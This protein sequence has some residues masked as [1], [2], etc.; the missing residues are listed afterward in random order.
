MPD[1]RDHRHV[2]CVDGNRLVY[3]CGCVNVID[4]ESGILRSVVKCPAHLAERKEVGKLG[5]DYYATM[6]TVENGI[7]QCRRYLEQLRE[8]IGHFPVA[9]G[10]LALEIGCGMSM[11]VPGLLAD[12]YDYRGVEPSE[13]A[14]EWTASTFDVRVHRGTIQDYFDHYDVYPQL[15][16]AA[17]VLEHL[18]DAPGTIRRC[19]EALQPGGEFWIIVPDD[20]D[21]LNP[22]HMW[23]FSQDTLA[24]NLKA[25]GLIVD[26][27]AVRRYISRENFL[28]CRARKPG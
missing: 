11:Y 18:D 26:R 21:P 1:P 5:M 24:A 10:D 19:A 23:F 22:D 25:A 12:R 7:P 6:G 3:V 28:Y 4:R 16:L 15:I 27:M 8:A 20:E 17:H 13:W 9:Y 14:A 2:R